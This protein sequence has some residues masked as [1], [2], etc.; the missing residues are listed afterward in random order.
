MTSAHFVARRQFWPTPL[1]ET[2]YGGTEAASQ[3]CRPP[4]PLRKGI[5]VSPHALTGRVARSVVADHI[6]AADHQ[7][8][9]AEARPARI[10][11]RSPLALLARLRPAG[12]RTVVTLPAP[13]EA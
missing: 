11:R 1:L 6:R 8:L 3:G 2:V 7:R 5:V 10:A 9:V 12:R 13:S 4:K